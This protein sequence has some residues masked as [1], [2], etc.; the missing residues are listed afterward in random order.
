MKVARELRE[1]RLSELASIPMRFF[2]SADQ[3]KVVIVRMLTNAEGEK[4]QH[5]RSAGTFLHHQT[6]GLVLGLDLNVKGVMGSRR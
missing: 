3:G 2:P 4:P 6:A 1:I 5:W